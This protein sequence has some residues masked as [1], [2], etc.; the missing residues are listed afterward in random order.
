MRTD[1]GN[2]A[3]RLLCEHRQKEETYESLI[4]TTPDDGRVRAREHEK[5]GKCRDLA[6]EL[7]GMC[8][9]KARVIIGIIRLKGG[10]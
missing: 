3:R 4:V 7:R 6:S 9:V 2:E 10:D 5:D 8:A 1:H